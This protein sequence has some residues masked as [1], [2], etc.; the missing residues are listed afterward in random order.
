MRFHTSK[1]SSRSESLDSMRFWFQPT[2]EITSSDIHL[3]IPTHTRGI[4]HFINAAIPN[5]F[6]YKLH[7]A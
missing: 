6:T 4:L 5:K 3:T 2:F 1:F 7:S